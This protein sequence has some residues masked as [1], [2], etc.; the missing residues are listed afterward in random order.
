MKQNDIIKSAIEADIPILLRGS[1]GIGKTASV[2]ALANEMG[3]HLETLIGSTLDPATV[4]GVVIPTKTSA[5]TI[6][7]DWALR[8]NDH[9]LS[10]LFLDELSAAPSS[11]IAAL[12]RI[13]HER[14]VDGI[15]LKNCR[16]VAAANPPETSADNGWMGEAMMN[17]FFHLDFQ[18]D[19]DT[20]ISGELSGWGAPLTAP[21]AAAAASVCAFLRRNVA[22]F[23]GT[24]VEGAYPSPRS[25]SNAI[26]MMAMRPYLAMVERRPLVSGN[27]GDAVA[28]E[29]QAYELARDLP[30]PEAILA[31]AKLPERGDQLYA[32]TLSLAAAVL[33]QHQNRAQR[34][35]RAWGILGSCRPDVILAAAAALRRGAPEVVTDEA[36][37]LGERLTSVL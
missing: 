10:I 12:L 4:S 5:T 34:I 17:R 28:K 1:P 27:V 29:W 23:I 3:A 26:R 13:V 6:P 2:K 36:V 8:I 24:P 19:L 15:T 9:P 31:G 20:W 14:R 37:H 7:P 32:A 35:E 25:W 33:A 21:H 16:V 22:A 11:V 18:A 30:D